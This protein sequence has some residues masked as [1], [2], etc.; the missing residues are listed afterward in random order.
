MYYLRSSHPKMGMAEMF[1]G[2]NM[3]YSVG[4]PLLIMAVV[5]A[6][7]LY[8]KPKY[9]M[10]KDDTS[11]YVWWKIIVVAGIVPLIGSMLLV[12]LAMMYLM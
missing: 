10:K 11:K 9:F 3:L 12:A 4:I 7:V 6:I 1:Q 8:K 2:K 5:L